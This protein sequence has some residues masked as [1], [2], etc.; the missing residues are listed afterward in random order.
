MS[1]HLLRKNSVAQGKFGKC[2]SRQGPE[3]FF[4]WR[5]VSDF[6]SVASPVRFQTTMLRTSLLLRSAR[7]ACR[8]RYAQTQASGL[9]DG[10]ALS[11]QKMSI[12]E[13]SDAFKKVN[14]M[15][16]S[17]SLK[18][19]RITCLHNTTKEHMRTPL[20]RVGRVRSEFLRGFCGVEDCALIIVAGDGGPGSDGHSLHLV[21]GVGQTHAR[22]IADG[23]PPAHRP[24]QQ[25]LSLI[26]I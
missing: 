14:N 18:Y 2:Q 13:W 26:H 4:F 20:S 17:T 24:E 15:R 21:P 22:S 7:G 19:V 23:S 9:A 16:I 25:P 8:A 11:I 6:W 10:Q 1:T 3:I 5:R 12:N